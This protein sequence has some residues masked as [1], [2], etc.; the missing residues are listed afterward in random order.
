MRLNEISI[1]DQCGWEMLRPL[2][3]CRSLPKVGIGEPSVPVE[4]PRRQILIGDAFE[5]L[6]TL[7]SASID[8]VVSSPPYYS[9]RDYGVDG[10]IG[11]E[12]NVEDWVKSLTDVFH[13]VARVL[14]P[15]GSLWLNLG[16][17]FSRHPKFGAPAKSM[18]AA[19]ERVLL[20]LIETGWVVRGKL[21]WNKPN[22]L[23]NSVADRLNVN[24]EVLYFLVRSPRYFFDLDSIREPH[25]SNVGRRGSSPKAQ[26]PAWA[27]PLAQGSQDGLRRF[28]P[29]GQPGHRLGKNPGSVWSIPTHAFRGGH[30]ATFPPELVRRPILSSCPEAICTLCGRPWRRQVSVTRI[31]VGP[32]SKQP[33]PRDR[34]VMRFKDRWHTIRTV[35]DLIPCG[36]QAPT[37]PGVV[38]DPFMGAGTVG[39]VAEQLGR[40]WLGIEIS[41]E[42]RT[43]ALERIERA[44]SRP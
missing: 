36:C 1:K 27:G 8:C 15:A 39:L 26:P 44:R 22:A 10:Q 33:A 41:P 30:F 42:Y 38:L 34:Q 5:Q 40:D 7:P 18:L 16:D 21:I 32:P 13:E 3:Y 35:G 20:A 28:R 4:V 29:A 25:R 12:P 19:P 31:P 2:G 37:V 43:L 6:R 9:L 14:K 17:S 24:Y 23:P 11:L